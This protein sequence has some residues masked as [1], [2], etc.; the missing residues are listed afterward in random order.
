MIPI[1]EINGENI[2]MYPHRTDSRG[3]FEKYRIK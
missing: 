1:Q 2:R 3:K